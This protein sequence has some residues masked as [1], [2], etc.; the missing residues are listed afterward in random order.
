MSA[1]HGRPAASDAERSDAERS[2]AERSDAFRDEFVEPDV[3]RREVVYRGLVWDVVRETFVLPGSTEEITRDFVD[4]PGAVAVLAVDDDDRVILIRQYRHPV[5]A[6]D[7]EIPAGLLDV[8]GEPAHHA[9]ARELAEEADLTAGTWHV[10]ADQLSS[11]GG[12]SE[13]LRIFL[14]R[15]L[16]PVPSS[17]RFDRRAEEAGIVVRRVP[18]DEAVDSVVAGR[19][20]N[21]TAVIGILQARLARERGWTGLRPADAPWP[22]RRG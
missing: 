9:A 5:R 19:V 4:H 2:G 15:D 10:L 8:E 22:A 13:T 14:A 16:A 21:G 12:L 6:R 17:E 20:T 3:V 1:G 18:L 7:W 11:P